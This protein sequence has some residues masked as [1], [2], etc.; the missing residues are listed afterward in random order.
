MDTITLTAWQRRRLQQQLRTARDARLYR[1]TLAVLA[2]AQGEPVASV[3]R[4][5]GVTARA[6]YYWIESYAY[7]HDPGALHDRDRPGRPALLT[8]TD[9]DLLRELLVGQSPQELGY[10]ATEW[11]VPLLQDY[12][13]RRTGRRP[14]DDTVRRELQRQGFVWKR[15]RYALDPDP[16]LRGKKAADSLADPAS[17]ASQCRPGGG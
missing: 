14:S 15:S 3:A 6:I 5:L 7:D 9:R 17:A 10:F 2:V 12:L 8:E 1:R 4:R 11:T 13:G 16:E